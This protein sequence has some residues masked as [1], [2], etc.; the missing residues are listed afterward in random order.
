MRHIAYTEGTLT[1]IVHSNH[2]MNASNYYYNYYCLLTFPILTMYNCDFFSL[3]I[4][5]SRYLIYNY[6]YPVASCDK[7]LSFFL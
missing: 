4:D 7:S 5:P 6:Y 2:S 3:K 1:A